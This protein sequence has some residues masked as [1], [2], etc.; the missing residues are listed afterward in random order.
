MLPSSHARVSLL[1]GGLSL[2]GAVLALAWNRSWVSGWALLAIP[3]A[4]L[5]LWLLVLR[6]E[7]KAGPV[8][9][10]TSALKTSDVLN[11]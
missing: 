11:P 1:Y 9:A 6:V 8:A 2:L 5:A 3:G 7:Q 4:G 10:P